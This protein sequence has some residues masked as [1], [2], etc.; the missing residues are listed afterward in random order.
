MAVILLGCMYQVTG[1]NSAK[2]VNIMGIYNFRECVIGMTDTDS[3][4]GSKGEC[5]LNDGKLS[6]TDAV[7]NQRCVNSGND[8]KHI[9]YRTYAI[10][11]RH[12]LVFS[13]VP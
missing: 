6:I 2:Q 9:K 10:A 3:N 13:R 5:R 4:F 12:S 8:S 1:I 11:A 7:E